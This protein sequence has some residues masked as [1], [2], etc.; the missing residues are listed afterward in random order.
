M[1][2][3]LAGDGRERRGKLGDGDTNGARRTG[4]GAST[5]EKDRSWH[6]IA[7]ASVQG[8]HSLRYEAAEARQGDP[9]WPAA[10]AG[11]W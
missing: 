8:R 7:W 2:E 3:V 4:G 5:C 10:A 9:T 11:A 1:L 6:F